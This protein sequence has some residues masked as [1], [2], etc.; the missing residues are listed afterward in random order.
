MERLREKLEQERA[1]D[2]AKYLGEIEALR[3]QSLYTPTSDCPDDS[4]SDPRRSS[5]YDLLQSVACSP[6][7]S[8][9]YDIAERVVVGREEPQSPECVSGSYQS[10][11][12]S[13]T[14]GS[15]PEGVF[16]R[17]TIEEKPVDAET[18]DINIVEKDEK[19][20]YRLQD[21]QGDG[22]CMVTAIG[23]GQEDVVK[24]C[25]HDRDDDSG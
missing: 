9:Q 23:D 1:Q 2:R 18:V 3:Q 25:G 6:P 15:S 5:T 11:F 7:S 14:P 20:L 22:Y 10:S 12:L 17:T 21:N 24:G 19:H 8:R 4:D 16:R 13:S